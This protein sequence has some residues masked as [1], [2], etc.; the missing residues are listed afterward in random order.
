M[1]FRSY[2]VRRNVHYIAT[3]TAGRPVNKNYVKIW[4]A[5]DERNALTSASDKD[6]LASGA[7]VSIAAYKLLL[8][9]MAL[10]SFTAIF[11][12]IM[13][14]LWPIIWSLLCKMAFR[15]L[16]LT[17]YSFFFVA[18]VLRPCV[19]SAVHGLLRSLNFFRLVSFI[20]FGLIHKGCL[21]LWSQA[22]SVGIA[23]R[24]SVEDLAHEASMREVL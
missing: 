13:R 24:T 3:G 17:S 6:T 19:Y 20:A 14:V 11:P 22:I 4:Q 1:L 10:C 18:R 12:G 9:G 7:H 16:S 23:I 15:L 2:S 5:Q 21:W 8:G